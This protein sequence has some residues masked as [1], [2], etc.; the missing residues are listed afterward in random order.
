PGIT[1]TTI[2][3]ATLVY[4]SGNF[5]MGGQLTDSNAVASVKVEASK[6]GAA[7][8]VVDTQAKSGTSAAWTYSKTVDT[9]GAHADD[10]EYAFRLTVTDTAGKTSVLNRLVR[11]DT[12]KPVVSVTAPAAASWKQG[13][14]MTI[15]GTASETYEIASVEYAIDTDGWASVTGLA[16]WFESIDLDTDAA[17]VDIGMAEGDHVLHMRAIDAAG[18]ESLTVDRAFSVDQFAP[19]LSETTVGTLTASKNALFTLGGSATDSGGDIT[20]G[21]T[22]NG[23]AITG[24]TVGS[25]TWSTGDLPDGGLASGTYVY[26]ITLTDESGKE[27]SL[28]RTVVVDLVGPSIDSVTNPV[29]SEWLSG[30]AYTARGTASDASSGVAQARYL[31]APANEDHSA[32]LISTWTLGT[33]TTSWTGTLNLTTIG[34]GAKKI[35]VRAQDNAGNATSTATTVAFGI[36]QA[37]PTL[38]NLTIGTGTVYKNATFSLGGDAADSNAL[39]RVTV[40]QAKN[41]GGFVTIFDQ[42]YSGTVQNWTATGLPRDPATPANTLLENGIYEY[43]VTVTDAASKTTSASRMVTVDGTAPTAG[44][45]SVAPIVGASTANG[46]LGFTA[47]ASDA[48]GITGVKWWALPATDADPTWATGGSTTFGA[49]PYTTTVDTTG[50]TDLTGYKLWVGALDAAGNLGTASYAVSV[51]QTS[52]VPSIA[53]ANMSASATTAG[54]ASTNLQESNAKLT[55]TFADDDSVDASTIEISIDSAA[56]F[57]AVSQV[58]SDGMSVGFEHNLSALAEGVHYFHISGSDLASAK[59]GKSAVQ[60]EIGPVYFVID[61]NPPSLAVTTAAQT[62]VSDPDFEISGT[63]SDTNGLKDVDTD[64]TVDVETSLDGGAWAPLHVTVGNWTYAVLGLWDGLHEGSHTLNVRATDI[65]NKVT[66]TSYSFVVDTIDATASVGSP[67]ADGTIVGGTTAAFT[68]TAVDTGGSGISLVEWTLIYTNDANDTNDGWAAATGTASWTANISLGA[69]AEGAKTFSLKITDNAGNARVYASARTFFLDKTPPTASITAATDLVATTS[70]YSRAFTL[71]VDA[72]D[73]LAL[74]TITITQDYTNTS[75]TTVSSTPVSGAALAGASQTY[76]WNKTVNT[77]THADDGTY[78]LTVTVTDDTLKSAPAITRTVVVDTTSPV[79][80]VEGV[81][82]GLNATLGQVNGTIG[83]RFSAESG[84]AAIEKSGANYL[85]YYKVFANGAVVDTSATAV[86]GWTLINSANTIFALTDDSTLWGAAGD[87]DFY[88]A[89]RDS[90]SSTPNVGWSK[91][92]IAMNQASDRPIIAYDNLDDAAATNAENGLGQ[93]PAV[94]VTVSDDDKVDVSMLEYRID[95]NND[96]DFGDTVELGTA[97]NKWE[98]ESVWY[99]VDQVPASDGSQVQGKILL[100]GIPQGLFRIV[101]RAKD[102]VSLDAWATIYDVPTDYHWQKSE[103]VRFAVSYGPPVVTITS[104][105]SNTYNSALSLQGS[106]IAPVGVDIVEWSMD[107]GS[108]WT[109]VDSYGGTVSNRT[110]TATIAITTYSSQEYTFMVKTSDLGGLSDTRQIPI[111]IDKAAP[112]LSFLQPPASDTVNG[113]DVLVRGEALDNRQ[114]EAVFVWSGLLTDPDPTP[115]ARSGPGSYTLNDY[116]QA[117]GT[118]LWSHVMDTTGTVTSPADGY[119][120][121]VVAFDT[122]GNLSAPTQRLLT[123][124]QNDDRPVITFSN[125][126]VG[127]LDNRVGAGGRIIG[128]AEDDDGVKLG[129]SYAGIQIMIDQDGNGDFSGS[130]WGTV[131]NVPANDGLVVTW[132]HDVSA[133]SQGKKNFKVRVL[134]VKAQAANV[135]EFSAFTD[136]LTAGYGYKVSAVVDFYIDYGPPALAVTSPTS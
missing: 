130:T 42:V 13:P 122:I 66:T 14:S 98:D 75:G 27:T 49:A 96:G 124:D 108:T 128:V 31:V 70:Y 52:D 50:L 104:P 82:S 89:V 107:S 45:A 85:A 80:S 127:A 129:S 88:V 99:P 64:S 106:A 86:A 21:L 10:G 37:Y 68:G 61:R 83:F 59:S 28:S 105:A 43:T 17:G 126:T 48:N 133:L 7:Y 93:N 40:A 87:Y 112:T 12:T 71:S 60:K 115:P 119:R 39:S 62:A 92:D 38:S 16:S 103:L 33:G 135:T 35:W 117:T 34:E 58:G 91:T 114:V 57:G 110:F 76:T 9:S 94:L 11:I 81:T 19:N 78:S 53:L 72:A 30:S 95:A 101:V 79:L 4:R 18:N 26:Q 20:I 121:R 54:Q 109:E 8:A 74:G 111:V 118:T 65:F 23:G 116:S 46:V 3:A 125:M 69:L 51:N 55:G 136:S 6:N 134:D 67:G 84:L 41:G 100:S 56:A 97:A 63:A 131:S 32:D 29:V 90:T 73:S 36:D 44:F 102:N 5:S 120:M 77:G 123:V 1:E 15:S 25:G 113:S 22:Q 132:Y 24:A 2:G 47:T